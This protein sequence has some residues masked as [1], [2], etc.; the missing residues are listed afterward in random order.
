MVTYSIE[1]DEVDIEPTIIN[2]ESHAEM[3]T[4]LIKRGFNRILKP[5]LP[6]QNE[7]LV[8][9]DKFGRTWNAMEDVMSLPRWVNKLKSMEEMIESNER[10]N[11]K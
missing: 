3:V 5:E 10:L 4:E 7:P 2:A 8:Y 11:R 1:C 9:I 6:Y